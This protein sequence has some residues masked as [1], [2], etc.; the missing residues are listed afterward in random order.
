M[1]EMVIVKGAL[2]FVHN[3][4]DGGEPIALLENQSLDRMIF[5]FFVGEGSEGMADGNYRI[6]IEKFEGDADL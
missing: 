6:T 1:V 3:P 4:V 2:R 5:E